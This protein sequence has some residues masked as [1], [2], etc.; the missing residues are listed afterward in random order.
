MFDET[1]ISKIFAGPPYIPLYYPDGSRPVYAQFGIAGPPG[2]AGMPLASPQFQSVN[3][4]M[5]TTRLPAA[6]VPASANEPQP[7]P[8][9]PIEIRKTFPETWI[10]DNLDFDSKYFSVKFKIVLYFLALMHF[11]LV[12]QILQSTRRFPTQSHHGSLLDS[13]LT[14]QL[15]WDLHNSLQSLQ[16]SNLSSYQRTCLIQ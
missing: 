3:R 8:P 15:V 12:H 14:L 16:F 7:P 9:K 6:T 4:E 1:V 2:G 13:P 10:F 5:L 11:L